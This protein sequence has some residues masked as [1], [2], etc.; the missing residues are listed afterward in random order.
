LTAKAAF[1]EIQAREY[2]HTL[3]AEKLLA[4]EIAK[5]AKQL[6]QRKTLKA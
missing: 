3:P 4:A 5:T 6:T 2:K 1:L